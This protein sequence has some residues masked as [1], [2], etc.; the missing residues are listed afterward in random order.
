MDSIRLATRVARI[1]PGPFLYGRTTSPMYVHEAKV[2]THEYSYSGSETTRYRHASV[3]WLLK[4]EL[5]MLWET[6]AR[7]WDAYT[8]DY[9]SL[10][11]VLLTMVHDYPGYAYVSAQVNHGQCLCQVH[12]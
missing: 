10:G 9:L 7:T 1:A 12:G 8:G 3:S 5:A 6:P 11:S 2:H 4:E